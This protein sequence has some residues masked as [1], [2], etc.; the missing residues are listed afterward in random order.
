MSLLPYLDDIGFKLPSHV[1]VW[2]NSNSYQKGKFIKPLQDRCSI[3][4]CVLEEKSLTGKLIEEFQ[5]KYPEYAEDLPY[6]IQ[7][8]IDK[9]TKGSSLRS[10]KRNIEN[11]IYRHLLSN[12]EEDFFPSKKGYRLLEEQGDK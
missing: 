3:F 10:L 11:E 8:V 5:K 2:I 4:N 7:R 6:L 9:F 1:L 12:K